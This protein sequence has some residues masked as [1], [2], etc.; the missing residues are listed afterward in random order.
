MKKETS[1]W[2]N[3]SK[4]LFAMPSKRDTHMSQAFLGPSYKQSLCQLKSY[5]SYT[6]QLYW[7]II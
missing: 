3:R 6:K 1:H 2:K 4:V 7:T 5:H